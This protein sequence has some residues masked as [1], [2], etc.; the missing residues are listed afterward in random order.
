L[1]LLAF[2]IGKVSPD[3]SAIGISVLADFLEN[4]CDW[5][6]G[7]AIGFGNGRSYKM[8]TLSM[9]VNVDRYGRSSALLR[10]F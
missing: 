6:G 2:A 9:G 8:Q 1:E 7:C 4:C 5:V 10:S 3:G